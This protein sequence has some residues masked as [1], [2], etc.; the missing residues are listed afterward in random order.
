MVQAGLQAWALPE[1]TKPAEQVWQVV[2]V[3]QKMQLVMVEAHSGT[4]TLL[5]RVK[6]DWQAE[7]VVISV[8]V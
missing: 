3:A 5:V 4:Q 1:R 7:Q 2:A 6:R 8:Q